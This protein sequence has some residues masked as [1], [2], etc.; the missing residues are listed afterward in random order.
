MLSSKLVSNIPYFR[1]QQV[2]RRKKP[3]EVGRD[4]LVHKRKEAPKVQI[5]LKKG[6][7]EAQNHGPAS[8]TGEK[9][10]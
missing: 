10:I 4:C 3:L 1:Y 8:F 2:E 6:K 7:D 5:A 9:K